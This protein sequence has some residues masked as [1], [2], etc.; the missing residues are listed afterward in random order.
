MITIQVRISKFQ[1]SGSAMKKTYGQPG[2]VK[3]LPEN[4]A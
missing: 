3:I 2:T 1:A 4:V